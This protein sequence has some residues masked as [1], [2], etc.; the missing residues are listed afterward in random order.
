[1]E[2]WVPSL[3]PIVF[4]N[5]PHSGIVAKYLEETIPLS[6]W[7]L[8]PAFGLNPQSHKFPKAVFLLRDG[9]NDQLWVKQN[10]T[11]Q[12]QMYSGTA[13]LVQ[14]TS[15]QATEAAEGHRKALTS[16]VPGLN[17]CLCTN[18]CLEPLKT[19]FPGT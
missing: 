18:V 12:E 2:H 15:F 1:M 19:R 6:H 16:L 11:G 14:A 8:T 17:M 13:A 7:S 9:L 4:V 10:K 3:F 5:A